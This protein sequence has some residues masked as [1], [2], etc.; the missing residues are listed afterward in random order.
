[1]KARSKTENYELRAAK[2][3]NESFLSTI[4][5]GPEDT[6][7]SL[8][9]RTGTSREF[10]TGLNPHIKSL[11]ELEP[12]I[13]LDVPLPTRHGLIRSTGS[14]AYDI[15]KRE[16]ALGVSEISTPGVDNPRIRLYHS[17]THGGAMPDEVSWCSSFVNYCVE[18]AGGAG[19]DSKAARSWLDWGRSV[20]RG[21]WREGDIVVFWR[22][23][24]NSW[25]G[26]VAFLVTWDGERPF[27]LGGNQ[28]NKICVDDPYPFSQILSVRR[29]H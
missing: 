6:F 11:E 18:Q 9:D 25:K 22:E 1:M 7:A 28:G 20:S 24:P 17:T 27:V 10:L 8:A 15:A 26:H 2:G 13:P 19:T 14:S 29:A 23:A 3:A 21:D 12:G 4:Y 5:T 16:K